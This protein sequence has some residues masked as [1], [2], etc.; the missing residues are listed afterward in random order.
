MK[1]PLLSSFVNGLL[2]GTEASALQRDGEGRRKE[3]WR[4]DRKQRQ[5]ERKDG[6]HGVSSMTRHTQAMVLRQSVV[7]SMGKV[8][9]W[10]R[11]KKHTRDRSIQDFWH[12]LIKVTRPKHWHV[13]LTRPKQIGER[14][15]S[16][17]FC[18]KNLCVCS[19]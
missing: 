1:R 9:F 13:Y 4:E 12:A 2:I 6:T 8:L 17:L 3:G 15:R 5:P 18:E 10:G 7:S 16:V 11:K 14:E 19:L